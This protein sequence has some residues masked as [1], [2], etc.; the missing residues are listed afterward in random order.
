MVIYIIKYYS[1]TKQLLLSGGAANIDLLAKNGL[2]RGKPLKW[3]FLGGDCFSPTHFHISLLAMQTVIIGTMSKVTA[4]AKRPAT[5]SGEEDG[6]EEDDS[7]PC[8][9]SEGYVFYLHQ[10][11]YSQHFPDTKEKDRERWVRRHATAANQSPLMAPMGAALP[12][13]EIG[14]IH[15]FLDKEYPPGKS[16][17]KTKPVELDSYIQMV[18]AAYESRIANEVLRHALPLASLMA[19][20]RDP[21]RL[22]GTFSDCV[23]AHLNTA[24]R[25]QEAQY[26]KD[27]EE[28]VPAFGLGFGMP[29]DNNHKTLPRN[30]K[31]QRK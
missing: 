13:Q 4:S 20:T 5:D 11:L 10:T 9:G 30:H 14:R 7:Y 18:S 25:F 8:L 21:V 22:F 16:S 19:A 31:R 29:P 28:A 24:A 23:E 17:K 15:N 1:T 12:M 26:N 3:S 6:E 27:N 2:A